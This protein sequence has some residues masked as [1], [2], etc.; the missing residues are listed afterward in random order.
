MR[1]SFALRVVVLLQAAFV[2]SSASSALAAITTLR[3]PVEYSDFYIHPMSGDVAAISLADAHVHLFRSADLAAGKKE[4][5]A[6]IQVGST[7]SAVCFKRFEKLELFAV[8]CEKDSNLYLIDASSG[9]LHRKVALLNGHVDA[10]SS[11][12]DPEDPHLYYRY[13]ER[14]SGVVSLRDY[15]THEMTF[16][17]S[18]L[19]AVSA[20]GETGYLFDGDEDYY[21]TALDR[22]FAG[23]TIWLRAGKMLR[24]YCLPDPFD[25]T[26]ALGPKIYARDLTKVEAELEFLPLCFLRQSPLLF[27]V[28]QDRKSILQEK[29]SV[30]LKAASYNSYTTVGKSVVLAPDEIHPAVPRAAN[31]PAEHKVYSLFDFQLPRGVLRREYNPGMSH[32]L[33][34]LPDEPR[35]QLIVAYRSRLDFVPLE[36]FQAPAESLLFVKLDAPPQIYAGQEWTGTLQLAD[37]AVE[38][39]LSGLPEG[40]KADGLTLRWTPRAGIG[41]QTDFRRDAQAAEA[42]AV[43]QI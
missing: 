10:I 24:L 41:R 14:K 11:S 3:L 16:D 2:W 32:L 12:L 22:K 31:N 28:S 42:A 7:P 34:I 5:A 37:P 19:V 9:K 26:I 30:V 33:R 13:G 38:V 35:Q 27:G 40:M 8:V 1:N 36:E 15:K 21:I 18:A 20:Q 25:R 17:H 23:E 4:P 39:V 6:K 43:L 29:S